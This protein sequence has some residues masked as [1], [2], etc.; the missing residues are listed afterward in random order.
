MGVRG[1]GE[2]QVDNGRWRWSDELC[3]AGRRGW[4]WG[5]LW[6][7]VLSSL[8]LLGLG[9]NTTCSDPNRETGPG[10]LRLSEAPWVF[11][12]GFHAVT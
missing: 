9:G 11:S 5:G 7:G 10:A 1:S 6:G 8:Q 2:G 12:C 3:L 4:L